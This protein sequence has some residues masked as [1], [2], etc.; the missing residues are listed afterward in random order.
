[1]VGLL[2][3]LRLTNVG[4]VRVTEST[5]GMGGTTISST[6]TT[7]LRAAIWSPGQSERFVS[8]KMARAS[9]HVL[10]TLPADYTFTPADRQV[11]YGG[12]TY[13]ITG[14]TDN[15]LFLDE[16]CVTGLELLT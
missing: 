14:P 6:T 10:V 8:D 9:T 5:D 11:T 13:R 15:V 3:W 4:I 16:I 7:L 2:D 1:M 12:N